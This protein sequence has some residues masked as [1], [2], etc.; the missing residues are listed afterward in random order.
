[1]IS[2]TFSCVFLQKQLETFQPIERA[3]DE[4]PGVC[5]FGSKSLGWGR[6]LEPL[7]SPRPAP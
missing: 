5:P 1:V 3:Q 4:T 7:F 2:G 6:L